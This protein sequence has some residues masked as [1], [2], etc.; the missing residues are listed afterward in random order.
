LGYPLAILIQ[1]GAYALI[2]YIVY[3]KESF[4]KRYGLFIVLSSI[5]GSLYSWSL[6]ADYI[7]DL[8]WYENL[9]WLFQIPILVL[10][11]FSIPLLIA[12]FFIVFFYLPQQLF[13]VL[14]GK[15]KLV[16]FLSTTFAVI[17]GF[18]AIWWFFPD[19]SDI[20]HRYLDGRYSYPT[21]RSKWIGGGRRYGSERGLVDNC[22]KYIPYVDQDK[23]ILNREGFWDT[24][25]NKHIQGL[26]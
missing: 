22:G 15:P 2:S 21:A 10:S 6:L 13:L 17:I 16:K 3:R 11:F 26:D 14:K 25:Y 5:A 4:E 20:C 19:E 1:L 9:F 12:I 24:F 18:V 8:E 7:I 23:L